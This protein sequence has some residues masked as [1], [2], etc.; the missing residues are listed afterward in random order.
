MQRHA[1]VWL[2]F[3]S[4]CAHTGYGEGVLVAPAAIAA[5]QPAASGK[6]E[7]DWHSQGDASRGELKAELPDGTVYA[8]D[9]L[10]LRAD[11]ETY[12]QGPYLVA[13]QL[14]A[15]A[16]DPWYGKA[17]QYNPDGSSDRV[18]ALLTD[19]AGD[20]M[21]CKFSLTDAESGMYGGG[22]GACL[23]SDSE[24]VLDAS[25]RTGHRH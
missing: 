13:P 9:Y 2:V 5:A 21:R 8:G 3:V 16:K 20:Q 6:V 19:A 12:T 23:L 17:P 10:Q 7:F 25:L 11:V 24:Q 22:A 4:A 1:F 15:W 14:P 18:V